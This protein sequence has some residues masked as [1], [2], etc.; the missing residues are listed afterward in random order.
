M[1]QRAEGRELEVGGALRLRLE[2]KLRS[3]VVRGPLHEVRR[4]DRTTKGK[5]R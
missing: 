1:E 2:A 5:K 3:L 4:K